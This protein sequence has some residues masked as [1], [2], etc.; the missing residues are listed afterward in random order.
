MSSSSSE[1]INIIRIYI[2]I[3]VEC[4]LKGT[5]IKIRNKFTSFSI[6]MMNIQIF[7]FLLKLNENP[8]H[9]DDMD[10]FSTSIFVWLVTNMS[11]AMMVANR[12][13][14]GMGVIPNKDHQDRT[15]MGL[16]WLQMVAMKHVDSLYYPRHRVLGSRPDISV[17]LNKQT[18]ITCSNFITNVK[19][20]SIF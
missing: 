8:Y 9:M 3:V 2:G 6:V 15:R 1:S 18:Y 12:M 13:R 11:R 20:N 14:P 10:V 19:L 17:I 16:A 7:L 5:E 4:H